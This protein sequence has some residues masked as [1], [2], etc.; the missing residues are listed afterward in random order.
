MKKRTVIALLM[1]CAAVSVT[2]YG[3]TTVKTEVKTSVVMSQEEAEK[4]DAEG[5]DRLIDIEDLSKYVKLAEYKGIELESVV[6]L[7][8]DEYVEYELSE[9]MRG[10]A[11]EVKDPVQEGDIATISYVGKKD[12][13]EFEGGSDENCDLEIG[14][15]TFIDGFEDGVIGMKKGETKDLELT[16]PEDY[17]YE[18][19]AG[20]SV[21]FTVTLQ[22]TSRIPE[23]S[24]EWIQKNT[25]C[26]TLE[27][28]KELIRQELQEQESDYAKSTL[29][30]DACSKV[31]SESEILE[32]P[33]E[34]LNDIIAGYD[35]S[36]LSMIE[37]YGMEMTLEEFIEDQGMT[38]EEY[39]EQKKY[40]GQEALKEK[41]VFQAIMDAEGITLEDEE[42]I[43]IQ[44]Q[45]LSDYGMDMAAFVDTFGVESIQMEIA[46]SR[47]GQLI[48]DNA[49]ITEKIQSGE[50][51]AENGDAGVEFEEIEDLENI[52]I[53]AED[54]GVSEDVEVIDDIGAI[55]DIEDLGYM[56]DYDDVVITEDVDNLYEEEDSTYE[57]AADGLI[58]E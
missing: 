41:M 25:T 17:A 30:Y 24:E 29:R 38:V 4:K 7:V 33:E 32:Y 58:V 43:K 3:K 12:G 11:E 14:S 55:E 52:D 46:Y 1:M 19:L 5:E 56:E 10:F 16:F 48:L 2:A 31:I 28:Y 49:K 54:M 44:D 21:V 51:V 27:E 23:L 50:T 39:E 45:L 53:Y 20:Q 47:V 22:K 8:S 35:E 42:S 36:V 26:K 40:Y 9:R 18:D 34:M 13:V 6:E 57:D 37:D 15:G